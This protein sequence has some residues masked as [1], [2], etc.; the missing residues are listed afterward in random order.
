MITPLE[1]LEH[2]QALYA[3]PDKNEV[4]LRN[5]AR[6][7]YYALFHKLGECQGLPN[8]ETKKKDFGSHEVLIQRLR[9]S[10][11]E[12]YREWGL[13]LSKLKLKR[14][15]A[16]YDL[17]RRFSDDDARKSIKVTQKIFEAMSSSRQEGIGEQE[18]TNVLF[19][20]C[21]QTKDESIKP[22]QP[23]LKVVK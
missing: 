2:S 17:S 11:N 10:D 4:V 20:G 9:K 16:D 14:T 13:E 6:N 18:N 19:D 15:K 22:C 8:L 23:Q 12:S 21:D 5:V 7:S 3:Q 1:L